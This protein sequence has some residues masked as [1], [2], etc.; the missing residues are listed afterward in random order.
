MVVVKSY[1]LVGRR[2]YKQVASCASVYQT[3]Q[4]LSPT[5]GGALL[6]LAVEANGEDMVAR[7]CHE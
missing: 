2:T 3:V 7:L 1:Y 5:A 4:T 6:L